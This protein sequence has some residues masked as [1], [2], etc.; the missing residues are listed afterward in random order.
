MVRW[1]GLILRHPKKKKKKPPRPKTPPGAPAGPRGRGG[2]W[3][4]VAGVGVLFGV[5]DAVAPPECSG[6]I[7]PRG[8][9][10]RFFVK[11]RN[12]VRNTRSQ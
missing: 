2:R 4:F 7:P 9:W 5:L 10:G 12:K 11:F 3:P 6:V 8:L 1:D